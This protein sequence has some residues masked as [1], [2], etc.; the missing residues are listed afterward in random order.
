MYQDFRCFAVLDPIISPCISHIHYIYIYIN[1]CFCAWM[2]VSVAS[3]EHQQCSLMVHFKRTRARIPFP[4]HVWTNAYCCRHVFTSLLACNCINCIARII[5]RKGKGVKMTTA[6]LYCFS[7]KT[8]YCL[9][10]ILVHFNASTLKNKDKKWKYKKLYIDFLNF[11]F[12][13]YSTIYCNLKL[14]LI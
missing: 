14:I 13:M 4:R 7:Y 2:P 11:Y 1:T 12:N 5:A 9:L 6:L 3:R 8:P 10:S